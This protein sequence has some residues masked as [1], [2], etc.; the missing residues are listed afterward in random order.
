M[1]VRA[2]SSA[3]SGLQGNDLWLDVI[4]NNIANTNSVGINRRA[5]CSRIV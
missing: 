2:F 1:V 3:V 4:G 5:P